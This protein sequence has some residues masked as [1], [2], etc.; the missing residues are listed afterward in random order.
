MKFLI[1]QFS[2]TSCYSICLRS[3]YS[4]QPVLTHLQLMF[5][6]VKWVPCHHGLR[7]PQV[8]GGG[9]CLHIRR[10][11]AIILNKQSRTAEKGWSSSLGVGR[12]AI[13]SS[14]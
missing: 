5:L 13:S 7:C 2:P 6:R 11:A 3:K 8:A 12:G 9:D 10:V 14:P 1:M 4:Q